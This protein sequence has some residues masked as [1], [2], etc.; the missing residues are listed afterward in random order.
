MKLPK[1]DWPRVAFS[2]GA[3]ASVVLVV[4]FAPPDLRAPLAGL[5]SAVAGYL[6]AGGGK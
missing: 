5:L 4:I 3:M 2:L 6:N 1:L